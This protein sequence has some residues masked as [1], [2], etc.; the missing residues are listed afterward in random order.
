MFLLKPAVVAFPDK[1]IL[2]QFW[3]YIHRS[4]IH[5]GNFT[6]INGTV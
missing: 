2:K 5:K 6:A 3:K 4:G 1:E